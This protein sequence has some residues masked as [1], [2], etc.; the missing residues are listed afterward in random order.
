MTSPTAQVYIAQDFVSGTSYL[1]L[2][3]GWNHE[4]SF[5][6]TSCA[7][8]G[9]LSSSFSFHPNMTEMRLFGFC[10]QR[11]TFQVSIDSGALYSTLGPDFH[12]ACYSQLYQ[13]PTLPMGF[14]LTFTN[15]SECCLA[16]ILA[17]PHPDFPL[18][19]QP[20]LVDD[21][22]DKIQYT[23][24]WQT[25]VNDYYTSK[26][27]Y[28]TIPM[29]NT[30]HQTSIV[31]DTMR[32]AF[33][34][35]NVVVFGGQLGSQVGNYTISYSV[36]EDGKTMRTFSTNGTGDV[37][38]SNFKLLDTGSLPSGD[39]TLTLTLTACFN[40]ALIVDYITYTPNF[41]T[42]A[43][44]PNVTK[45]SDSSQTTAPPMPTNATP[46]P[47]LS[48]STTPIGAIVGGSVGG[49]SLFIITCVFL[50]W[51]IRRRRKLRSPRYSYAEQPL[52][53][54]HINPYTLKPA[55]VPSPPAT[56]T[57]G[58][59]SASS[60]VS[61]TRPEGPAHEVGPADELARVNDLL[62]PSPAVS[63]TRPEARAQDD[64]VSPRELAR[65][66]NEL[67]CQFERLQSAVIPPAYE[68]L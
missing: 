60:P 7:W 8:A 47:T 38:D 50:F 5:V 23:G 27:S 15:S 39:H 11:V 33:S 55:F 67:S 14:N 37:Y 65:R 42:L 13:S 26:F 46:G 36:D 20:L 49:L 30:T 35:T 41:A 17:T 9:S 31:G 32:F 19:G 66:V 28:V 68:S 43:K 12:S 64:D 22:Y 62:L 44:M 21:T 18:P 6:G 40:Q 59:V 3:G 45:P 10:Y 61:A 24:S 48:P 63:A 34:G 57:T 53:R 1:E 16:L 2:N 52:H 51:W 56:V 54:H 29:M 25:L 58:T 4:D